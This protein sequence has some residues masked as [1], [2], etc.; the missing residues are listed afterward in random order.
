M[1]AP[2]DFAPV[3]NSFYVRVFLQVSQS[4]MAMG[5]HVDFIEGAEQ[6]DDSG[7]ELRLGAS[8]GM[9]DLNLIPGNKGSKQSYQY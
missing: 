6:I 5:G 8:H 9:V 3:D 4:T 2:A 1:G 7:D